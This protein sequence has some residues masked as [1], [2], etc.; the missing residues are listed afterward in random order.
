MKCVG[1]ILD[2]CYGAYERCGKKTV[3]IYKGY[4]LC[5]SCYDFLE[6][7]DIEGANWRKSGTEKEPI[8]FV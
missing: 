7:K 3:V 2:N 8:V 5:Q 4:S 1:K 6:D